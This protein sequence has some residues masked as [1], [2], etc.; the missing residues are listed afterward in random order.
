MLLHIAFGSKAGCFIDC[1]A[2]CEKSSVFVVGTKATAA[3]SPVPALTVHAA[4]A[5]S[6]FWQFFIGS[7]AWLCEKTPSL[8]LTLWISLVCRWKSLMRQGF[9]LPEDAASNMS[10]QVT[11]ARSHPLVLQC[12]VAV[13]AG[14]IH[15]I[16]QFA[17]WEISSP[18]RSP[19]Q[20]SGVV[21]EMVGV[22]PGLGRQLRRLRVTQDTLRETPIFRVMSMLNANCGSCPRFRL[23]W[24]MPALS[25]TVGHA[26]TMSLVGC[27][28]AF[29]FCGTRP[30]FCQFDGNTCVFSVQGDTHHGGRAR[31][32]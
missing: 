5:S 15:G 28:H 18:F 13:H 32:D 8:Q 16:S 26:L 19:A 21:F 23:L 3:I 31:N 25:I 12:W 29:R 27:T 20:A 10:L 11:S 1:A 7:H 30:T 14:M 4:L 22:I 2:A 24:V 9:V 6:L 17:R